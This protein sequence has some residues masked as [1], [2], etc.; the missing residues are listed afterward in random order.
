MKKSLII[1]LFFVFFILTGV[2]TAHATD[3][4]PCHVLLRS[5]DGSLGDYGYV[6]VEWYSSSHCSGDYLGH[7]CYGSVTSTSVRGFG[8][9]GTW[10]NSLESESISSEKTFILLFTS[11]R[12]SSGSRA[13]M[14]SI[15]G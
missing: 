11:S 2:F 13:I 3:A 6:H 5:Y 10:P 8:G 14:A 1:G 9:S 15:P 4:Y 12:P 7:G